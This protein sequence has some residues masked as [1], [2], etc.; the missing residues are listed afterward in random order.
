MVSLRRSFASL[1]CLV[2]LVAGAACGGGG[3]D[4]AA[5]AA[6][7]D[8]AARQDAAPQQDAGTALVRMYVHSA[9]TLFLIDDVTFDLTPIGDFHRPSDEPP[10]EWMTDLA[11]TP[12]G[13]VY[14]ISQESLYR[15]DTGSA[16]ATFLASVPG[17]GNVGMTFL[18]GGQLLAT[19]QDGGVRTVDPETGA[20][21][22]LGSFGGGYATAGDLVAIAD[23]RMFAISDEG[24][25]GDEFENNV[26]LTVDPE[27]G[28]YLESVGQIG[29]GRVFGAAVANQRIY[30]FTELGE[31]IEIDPDTGEGT[32]VR[33]HDTVDFWGAGV[34]PLAVVD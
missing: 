17:K 28:A 7:A 3:G 12:D 20:V 24:P 30:A 9:Q 11:V 29:Y 26:L 15:I 25:V 6:A 34:S 1:P 8:A 13:A 32:L 19:D 33:V 2:A 16:R 14:T 18:A 5:D 4:G 31:I 21:T 22:E 23:G 10:V 27:T